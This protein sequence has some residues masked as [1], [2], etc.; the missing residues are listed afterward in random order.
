MADND[1]DV[2]AERYDFDAPSHVVDF[3]QLETNEGDDQW[4]GEYL[5][6][7]LFRSKPLSSLCGYYLYRSW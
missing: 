1:S 3:K 6:F 5:F 7:I 4:F 2:A